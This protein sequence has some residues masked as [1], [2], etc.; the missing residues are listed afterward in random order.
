MPDEIIFGDQNNPPSQDNKYTAK[1]DIISYSQ[2]KPPE[3]GSKP[4]K[5]KIKKIIIVGLIL[6]LL[7]TVT[8]SVIYFLTRSSG[9][10]E[11]AG[12]AQLVYWGL[13]ED[14]AVV[15]FIISEF[16]KENPNIKVKYEK[17][18]LQ[19]YK[20]KLVARI[21]AERGPDIFRFHNSWYSDLSALL[22][23]LPGEVIDKKDFEANFYSVHQ[24]DLIKNG[25]I[26][27]IPLEIDTLALFVNPEI[28]LQAERE[29]AT[30]SASP[31]TW[32]EFI[33]T[34]AALT[35]KDE[36]GKILVGGAGIGTYDN[37]NNAPDII[38]L[39]FAQNRADLEDI[40]ASDVKATDALRFYTN[41]ALIANNVWSNDLDSTLLAFSQGRLAMYF[42]FSRDYNS[43]K[44]I[45]PS[46]SFDVI[47]IPQLRQDEKFNIANYYA[48]GIST[49]SRHQKEAFVFLEYLSRKETQEKIWIEASKTQSLPI[50]P[51][52]KT[53]LDSLR[54]TMGFVFAEQAQ[55]AASSPY[56]STE[57][58]ESKDEGIN[59]LLKETVNAILSGESPEDAIQILFRQQQGSL[60]NVVE[61]VTQ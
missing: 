41:F 52:N 57:A 4:S 11:D 2:N 12:S 10:P 44:K 24:K 34:S 37:V 3:T 54:G 19:D 39:L 43:I 59:N 27:G 61:K 58:G 22:L 25:A 29:G 30:A 20:E 8:F 38:S 15:S 35:K 17:Q 48:E 26:Y 23:P 21:E 46:L 13:W 6:F 49:H 31:A 40:A 5:S 55:T 60:E 50:P 56:A 1:Q 53:L 33:E 36:Q 7:L 32:Q 9:S 47:P 18:D 16:E 28:V 42:G 14:P 45:N 51:G